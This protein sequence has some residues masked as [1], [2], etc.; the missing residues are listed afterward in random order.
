MN[1][2]MG[3]TSALLDANGTT[4]DGGYLGNAAFLDGPNAAG[5]SRDIQGLLKFDSL[6]GNLGEQIKPDENILR[7]YLVLTTGST[8]ESHSGGTFDV[9]QMLTSW[10]ATSTFGDFGGDGP[11]VEQNEI[12]QPLATVRGMTQNSQALLDVTEAVRA[13]QGGE[14]NYGFNV[15]SNT[16]DGWNVFFSGAND[17]TTRPELVVVTG[18]PEP[19]SAL[20]LVLAAGSLLGM[21]RLRHS[22]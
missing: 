4:T 12:G 10:D 3:S 20:L 19:G 15:Q 1:G 14:V 18:V 9:H 5:D 13:W 21:R 16:T 7:A 22:R 8:G 2:Y 11:T 6:F 17:P